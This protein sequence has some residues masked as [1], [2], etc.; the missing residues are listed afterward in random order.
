MRA[1]IINRRLFTYSLGNQKLT[2]NQGR[3]LKLLSGLM[4]LGLGS[5]LLIAPNWLNTMWVSIAVISTAIILTLIVML[6]EKIV[7]KRT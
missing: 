7:I 6:I 4:M 3:L 5:I 2:E 1:I